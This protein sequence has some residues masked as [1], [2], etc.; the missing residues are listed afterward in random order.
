MTAVTLQGKTFQTH[1]WQ[2]ATWEEYARLRDDAT[3]ERARIFF[4]QGWLWMDV[5]GEGINHARISDLFTL[6]F[7]FWAMLHPETKIDS[8]GRCQLEK[9]GVR[10]AA[11]D[12]VLYI[13]ENAPG[14]QVGQSR[15]I[16]LDT[17]KAPAL[18]GEISDTTLA[19]D[20]D[21]KKR[22]YAALGIS[23]YWVIN[24]RGKQ[25][26]FFE[27]QEDGTYQES[28]ASQALQGLSAEL[29]EQTL[30]RLEAEPNTAAALWLS[31]QLQK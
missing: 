2:K 27:L 9:T 14:W 25:A 5:G 23:E 19:L 28:P 8:L 24:V 12:L 11:P 21:Q 4:N 22:I 6:I 16:N 20:M 17:M 1:Q 29:L 18:V 7:G 15:Y 10:G 26:I 13:G 31:Q 30:E 3:I